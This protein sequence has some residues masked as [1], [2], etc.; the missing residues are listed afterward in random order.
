MANKTFW[1]PEEVELY[2]K[3]LK[4]GSKLKLPDEAYCTENFT[5]NEVLQTKER[6]IDM[7]S[8][9]ILENLKSSADVLQNYRDKTGKPIKITSGWR[10]P[11]EQQRLI[12]AYNRKDGT[13]K[14]KPSETSLHLE[15]LALDFAV[16][17]SSQNFIQSII[18]ETH[19]GEMEFGSNY[20]HI[21]LPTFSKSYLQRNGIYSDKIYRKLNAENVELS[22]YA[23]QKIIKRMDAS[24]WSPRPSHFDVKKNSDTFKDVEINLMNYKIDEIPQ[25]SLANKIFTREEIAK[26]S[27]NEFTK[28]EKSIDKQLATIGVPTEYEAQEAVRTGSMIWVD[29]YKR[30]DGTNVSG[31]YRSV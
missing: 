17:G 3:N 28:F 7:P 19:M 22:P 30:Q 29:S 23:K 16:Q 1:S 18:D 4:T 10:T 2:F 13:Q 15:G 27:N 21:G 31:Y 20:T 9:Q 5:W 25:L 14:N 12:N 26:M 8:R 6:N 24:N 11:T